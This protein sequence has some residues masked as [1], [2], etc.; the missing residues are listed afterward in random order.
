MTTLQTEAEQAI[1]SI[2]PDKLA[3]LL[4]GENLREVEEKTGISRQYINKLKNGKSLPSAVT[5]LAL[6][7]YLEV[8]PND[9]IDPAPI[10]VK[11]EALIAET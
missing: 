7:W 11:L 1:R 4:E 9:L 3:D 8:S 2:F 6:S 10:G 5:L